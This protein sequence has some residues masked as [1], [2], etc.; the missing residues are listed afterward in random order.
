M[1]VP[2]SVKE[3]EDFISDNFPGDKAYF[4]QILKPVFKFLQLMLQS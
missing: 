3:I 1:V 2:D 4:G